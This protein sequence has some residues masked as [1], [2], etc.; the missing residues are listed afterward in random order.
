MNSC[1]GNRGATAVYALTPRGMELGRM[2]AARLPADL[3][4]HAGLCSVQDE[5][6]RGVRCF[7]SLP[8]LIGQTFSAYRRHVFI[9]AC[10]IAT[11]CVAP[12]LRSKLDDPAVLAIDQGGR[13][14]VSLL[15]GHLGGGN[16]LAEEV[17][18][19][20]GGVA[21]ITSATD[22]EGA[23][24]LDLIAQS[25][26]LFIENIQAL[27]KV[28]GALLR[29][30]RVGVFD[31]N[32][33]LELRA[34]QGE[35]FIFC[36]EP[37]KVTLPGVVVSCRFL[38]DLS[39]ED[40][41]FLRPKTLCLGLGCRRGIDAA[42]LKSFIFRVLTE[43]GF[44]VHALSCLA[45]FEGKRDEAAFLALREEFGLPFYFF[46]KEELAV[47]PSGEP[48]AK[49]LEVFGLAG[50]CE[51]AALMASSLTSGKTGTLLVAKQKGAGMTMALAEEGI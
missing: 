6:G 49:A 13:F 29:G 41:L 15:S 10:G 48:S 16:A 17:A 3:F 37:E 2:I 36:D 34:E 42:E 33:L 44:S 51:S 18:A 28:S 7:E 45:S 43:K 9:C 39:R 31:P 24:S 30:E 35:R 20:T 23:P 47:F 19:L 1:S 38:P 14:A 21:V 40:I 4:L 26:G 12:H 25:K 8:A 46:S 27:K 5:G 32:D 22:Y 11:R 50:V